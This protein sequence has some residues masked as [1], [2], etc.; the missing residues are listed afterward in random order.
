MVSIRQRSSLLFSLPLFSSRFLSF[1][2]SSPLSSSHISRHNPS[3]LLSPREGMM[4]NAL[5]GGFSSIATG[6]I[7]K[8]IDKSIEKLVKVRINPPV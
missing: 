2:L 5:L 3:L 1:P 4:S 7:K 6:L 8:G